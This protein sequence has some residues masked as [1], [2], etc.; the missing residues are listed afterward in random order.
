ML[1][2]PMGLK[3]QVSQVLRKDSAALRAVIIGFPIPTDAGTAGR[4]VKVT[5]GFQLGKVAQHTAVLIGMFK[6][7]GAATGT[8]GQSRHEKY[9]NN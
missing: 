3:R 4:T 7:Q 9:S 8:L 2:T 1:T 6:H 5:C